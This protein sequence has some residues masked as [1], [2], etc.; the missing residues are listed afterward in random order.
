MAR[1]S[2]F[3]ICLWVVFASH[4]SLNAAVAQWGQSV[5]GVQLGIEIEERAFQLGEKVPLSIKFTNSTAMP[6]FP[7]GP[8]H[9]GCPITV[10]N[11][12]G[13]SVPRR[14]DL[15]RETQAKAAGKPAPPAMRP[16]PM[17]GAPIKPGG[18]LGFAADLLRDFA[19]D[20]PGTYRVSA[21]GQVLT[22]MPFAPG[23]VPQPIMSPAVVVQIITNSS[24]KPVV[25]L[26]PLL[27]FKGQS[28]SP[29][30]VVAP[31]ATPEVKSRPLPKPT[32]PL[33]TPVPVA[34]APSSRFTPAAIGAVV[35]GVLGLLVLYF[36]FRS[37]P[38]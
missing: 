31:V 29:P 13:E 14:E 1:L 18:A 8:V 33:P 15:R 16:P 22:G 6:R 34:A 26:S 25:A 5:S 28:N 30:P 21:A 24:P 17:Y 37:G 32:E 3:P 4:C 38:R 2:L 27:V 23:S 11:E 20:E 19:I 12:K 9:F 10:Q 36:M 7:A 35:F